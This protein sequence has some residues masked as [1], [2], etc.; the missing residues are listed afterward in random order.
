MVLLP[1]LAWRKARFRAHGQAAYGGG[2]RNL[3]LAAAAVLI[4]AASAPVTPAPVVAAERAFAQDGGAM[5]VG[6]SFLKWSV[7]DA[8]M[9]GPAG[10]THPKEAFAGPP[11]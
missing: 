9:I 2:M 10:V 3:A 7:P 5:G 11:P 8:V 1:R 6:P 4:T